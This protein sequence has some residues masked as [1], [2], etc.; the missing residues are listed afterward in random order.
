MS[1]EFN[2]TLWENDDNNIHSNTNI[3]PSLLSTTT[4]IPAPISTTASTLDESEF[5]KCD[6]SLVASVDPESDVDSV[7]WLPALAAMDSNIWK[8]LRW[9]APNFYFFFL[10]FLFFINICIYIYKYVRH[11]R[12]S[13]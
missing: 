3:E 2:Q 6:A 12:S 7:A 5:T 11:R 10:F 13:V 8:F 4:L 1:H 9:Y